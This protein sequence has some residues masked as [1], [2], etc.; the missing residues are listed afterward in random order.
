VI[1][2]YVSRYPGLITPIY[3][4]QN[5]GVAQTRNDALL[6][7]TGDYVSYVDGDDRFLPA[8]LEKEAGLLREHPEAQIAYSNSYFITADGLRTEVLAYKRLP[9]QGDVFCQVFARDF[10]DGNF[11]RM[12]L[13]PYE[14]WK[15]AGFYDPIL[16]FSEDYDIR[17]RLSKHGRVVYCDEPLS[18]IRRHRRGLSTNTKLG[19]NLAAWEHILR[20]NLHLLDDLDATARRSIRRKL[21]ERLQKIIAKQAVEKRLGAGS[22]LRESVEQ[23]LGSY[24]R[25]LEEIA[26]W[27][28]Q[29]VSTRM[30]GGAQTGW[31]YC[32]CIVGWH[33]FE[34]FYESVYK[35]KGD[36]YI[37]SHRDRDF[38]LQ[39]KA[40]LFE[41]VK[42][43]VYFCPNRGLDW[44]G[45]HQFNEMNLH[46]NYDFVIY[47]HD[48]LAIKNPGFV[49]A[50]KEKFQETGIKVIGNGN[51]GPDTEFCYAKYKD[52]MLFK[53]DDDFVIRSVRGS[54]FAA[55]TEIFSKIGNFPAPWQADNEN[56]ETGNIALRNFAYLVTKNF[57]IESIAYL[58]AE[59]RLETRYLLEMRRGGDETLLRRMKE[60]PGVP[61]SQ[62]VKKMFADP[63]HL[64]MLANAMTKLHRRPI[65]PEKPF[66]VEDGLLS[67]DPSPQTLAQAYPELAGAINYIVETAKVMHEGF[68]ENIFT[69][70][71]G[72]LH[73]KHVFIDKEKAW[74]LGCN[75]L[76]YADPAW[77][78]AEVFIFLKRTD[79]KKRM[80]NYIAGLLEAFLTEYFSANDW[81]IAGR[82]PLYEAM[83][84]LKRACNRFRWR[85]EADWQEQVKLLI[86][87]SAACL[88]ALEK[89]RAR[90]DLEKAVQ[91][92]HACPGSV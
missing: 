77:D 12:E 19:E 90:L 92:Y 83:I 85:E 21:N 3:H 59:N 56:L 47:C 29:Q 74:L 40:E 41:K 68:G 28:N 33:F 64:R 37:I 66:T 10:P 11:F 87:Q 51:N 30:N 84:H 58:D 38:L 81:E 76:K 22:R 36:K 88:S 27:P 32:F 50:L 8:K 34:D 2:G 35:I 55:R 23:A 89:S 26:P 60:A 80:S 4:A 48:D 54:F 86:E 18:E 57:G 70:I 7:V 65:V 45:Y 43:D 31:R 9:P 25:A 13:A 73:P 20:K 91:L 63:E 62:L 24:L 15:R 44:G 16:R 46:Y 82:I 69:F 72:D 6:A 14:I 79:K 75:S 78:L 53:D 61:L 42:N 17:I 49:E 1:A 67:C 52:G 39:E 5:L 71:H